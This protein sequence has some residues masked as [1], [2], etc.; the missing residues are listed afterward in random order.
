MALTDLM[1]AAV[2]RV[3]VGA[4]QGPQQERSRVKMNRL[5]AA[6]FDILVEG[7]PSAVTTTA[8]AARAGVSTGW[9]YRYFDSREAL[10]EQVLVEGLRDLDRRLDEID[11]D[12]AG[13]NWRTKA[14]QGIDAHIAFF[15]ELVWFRQVWFSSEFSGR[16]IQA[17][18][19]HDNELAAYLASTIT[20]VRSDAPDVPLSVMTTFFIGMLD[21][22]VDLAY[23]DDPL[24]G[25]TAILSEMKRSSI[26]YLATFLAEPGSST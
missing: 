14:A 1:T 10:L 2:E 24:R 4:R 5:L 25:N 15:G 21:K 12:L 20:E 26:D 11:F 6:T 13:S 16:M 7:G 23:R 3:H 22:G 18:R 8:V 17:N 9:L 19:I